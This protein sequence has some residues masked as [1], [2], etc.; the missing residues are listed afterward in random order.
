MN[1]PISRIHTASYRATGRLVPR[2]TT[3]LR[4]GSVALKPGEAM[5]WHSTE[6]REEFLIILAGRV[7]LQTEQPSIL[8]KAGQCAWL[9][10]HTSHTVRNCS[11]RTARYLYV[12]G[13]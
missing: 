10:R 6:G 11:R 3:G 4:A 1:A 7:H 5:P 2:R 9:P 12:T 8:L 13:T